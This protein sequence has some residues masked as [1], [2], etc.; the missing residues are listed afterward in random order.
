MDVHGA[1]MGHE[2]VHVL[3]SAKNAN[4]QAPQAP[5]AASLRV[6]TSAIHAGELSQT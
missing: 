3:R 4:E 1:S 6:K 5:Q 2:R